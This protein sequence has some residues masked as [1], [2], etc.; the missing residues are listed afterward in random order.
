ML[1][2]NIPASSTNL[3][4]PQA[5]GMRMLQAAEGPY[6]PQ[7]AFKQFKVSSFLITLEA[8]MLTQC[9]GRN[10]KVLDGA[11]FE[12]CDEVNWAMPGNDDLNRS[13]ERR[14]GKECRS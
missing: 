7:S 2:R 8:F 9:S 11:E 10:C 13:E 5:R 14:V 1:L 4:P 3:P 6:F 12:F